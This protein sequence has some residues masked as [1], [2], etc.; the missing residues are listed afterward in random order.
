VYASF[1]KI[2]VLSRITRF[3]KFSSEK[4]SWNFAC[5]RSFAG[6]APKSQTGKTFRT[7]NGTKAKSGLQDSTEMVLFH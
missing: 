4:V 6:V 1:F 7:A 2:Y 5:S 3:A